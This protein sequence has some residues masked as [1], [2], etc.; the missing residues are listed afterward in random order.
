M[1]SESLDSFECWDLLKGRDG[2]RRTV[3][4]LWVMSTR[5]L[6]VFWLS[7]CISYTGANPEGQK[8]AI[9]KETVLCK[10]VHIANYRD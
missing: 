10:L 9:T 7:F 2:E 8:V 5:V 3:D 4:C 1:C 6:M